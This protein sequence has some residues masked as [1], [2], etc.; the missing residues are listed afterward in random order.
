MGLAKSF[1][2]SF[3][4]VLAAAALLTPAAAGAQAPPPPDG[5]G[6]P[7]GAGLS[8]GGLTPPPPLTSEADPQVAAQEQELDAGKEEDSGRGLTWFWVNVEGGFQHVGLQTFNVDEEELTAG[9]VETSNSGGLIG[10]GLGLRLLFVTLGPRARIGFFSDWQLFSLGGEL[11]FHIPIGN[12]EPHLDL[13]FGY[14]G[15]GSVSGAVAG[16]NDA[17]E[18]RGIY[19]RLGGGLDYFVTPAFS[20]GGNFSWELLALTRPGLSAS[21]IEAIESESGTATAEETRAD[22]LAAEGSGYGSAI[23]ITAQLGL[24][25]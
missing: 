24:H 12:I 3:S 10:A 17:I 18:I 11:G 21:E 22:V 7:E 5:A 1:R 4:A 9:F 16:A 13:G 8:A 6:Q 14:T 25:F 20:V 19:A 2:A 15:L 23:A